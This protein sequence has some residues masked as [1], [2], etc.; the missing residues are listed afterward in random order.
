[1]DNKNINKVHYHLPGLFEFVELYKKFLPLYY[2]HSE[3]FYDWCDIG[4]IYGAPS[5]SLWGGGR[6]GYGSNGVENEVLSL[7]REFNFSVRLTFS[8]SLLQQKHLGDKK[9]NLLCSKFH[10]SSNGIIIHSDLL[11]DHIKSNYPDFYFVS[12]TTKVLASFSEFDSE[13]GRKE[14]KYV[15]PD[16]RL[17]KKFDLLSNLPA[18]KKDKTEFLC[19]EDCWFDCK[20]RKQCYEYVSGQVLG[21]PCVDWKCSSP[22]AKNGYIFSNAM[23]NPGFIGTREILNI[24][25]PMGFTSFKIEGRSLGSALILEFLLFYMTRPEYQLQVREKIYLDNTLDLF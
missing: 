16:F 20:T 10:S 9:C 23:K 7:S 21:I 12:S 24:Y 13:L 25:M 8:N 6:A 1:M 18:E 3:F 14:F 15:V 11:M 22:D 19:N 4:S 2:E 5:E 17:N